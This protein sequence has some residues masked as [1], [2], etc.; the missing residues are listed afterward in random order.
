MSTT[1]ILL[2]QN[3][4]LLERIKGDLSKFSKNFKKV[5]QA[6]A[7]LQVGSLTSEVFDSIIKQDLQSLRS[8]YANAVKDQL[9]ASGVVNPVLQKIATEGTEDL[10][11]EFVA[12]ADAFTKT[13]LTPYAYGKDKDRTQF[14]HLADI[15]Y[16]DGELTITPEAEEQILDRACRIYVESPAEHKLYQVLSKL[17]P[18][19]KEFRD[20]L[21]A[22]GFD[23]RTF[24]GAGVASHFID[25]F[26][27]VKPN[28]E[29]TIKASSVKWGAN[30]ERK[31]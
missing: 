15:S 13:D 31:Y 26:F 4:V 22:L 9:T 1:R 24:D 3:D 6:F 12:A 28:K 17:Q 7:A 21:T 23:L 5:E 27:T 16:Q 29:V 11:N 20:E 10:F 18:C 30:G 14:L 19:L 25:E 8:V 2:Q